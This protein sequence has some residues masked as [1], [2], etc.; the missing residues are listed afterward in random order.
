MLATY[1][2]PV[3]TRYSLDDLIYSLR[4]G[5]TAVTGVRPKDETLAV[6]VAKVRLESGNGAHVWND[7]IGN[8]KRASTDVGNFTCI[9]L[10]EVLQVDGKAR[11]VWFRPDGELV[12]DR[13]SALKGPPVAVPDGHVQTRM[14]H[15]ANRVDAGYFYCDFIFK[16]ARYA[17][18]MQ[19][20]LAGN[21]ALY[22]L[23]LSKAG[24]Y[25]APVEQY[26]KT[27][28][29]LYGPSLAR[30]KNQPH[31]EVHQ[32]AKPEWHN[33]LLIDGYVTA[34]WLDVQDD[35]NRG[36]AVHQREWD[37]ATEAEEEAAKS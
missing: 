31:E 24:Y 18:A 32:P 21:P 16:R 22:A 14:A 26:T 20:M 12:G 30:I 3:V 27:V 2:R 35:L 11:L 23:E 7:N 9:V 4:V 15:L 13:S 33:Q 19:A 28:V 36:A 29:A 37:L 1:T 34:A 17:K 6:A 8:I 10:N 5:L 25:T